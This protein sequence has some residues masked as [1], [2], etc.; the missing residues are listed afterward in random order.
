MVE[1]NHGGSAIDGVDVA[2]LRRYLAATDVRFAVLFGARVQGETH[3][4]SDIDVALRFS[5][6]LSSERTLPSAESYQ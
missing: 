6:E 4:S 3:D 2:A 1:S 5:E